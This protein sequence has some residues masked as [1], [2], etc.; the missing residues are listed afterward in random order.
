M[1]DG[2]NFIMEPGTSQRP[3]DA[4]VIGT[5]P[6][7]VLRQVRKTLP[8]HQTNDG[9]PIWLFCRRLHCCG[10]DHPRDCDRVAR[11]KLSS[12]CLYMMLL[13][14]PSSRSRMARRHLNISISSSSLRLFLK[15]LESLRPGRDELLQLTSIRATALAC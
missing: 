10:A 9:C 2:S 5:S 4:Q 12:R 3:R 8:F 11:G 1:H 13:C 15:H 7:V 6:S 14:D